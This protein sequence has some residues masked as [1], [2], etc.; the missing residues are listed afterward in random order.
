MGAM[1]RA[2]NA[3]SSALLNSNAS[4]SM[5]AKSGMITFIARNDRPSSPGLSS[6]RV[7]SRKLDLR[8]MQNSRMAMLLCR[9][10]GM[11]W[12]RVMFRRES[13]GQLD[14]ATSLI[15]AMAS[16]MVKL[17]GFC[18]GGNSLKVSTNFAAAACAA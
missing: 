15:F 17:P 1:A 13:R 10:S 6:R 12:A 18:T 5:T 4:A 14:P 11:S 16:S 7:M 3:I 2:M 9:A 8:A